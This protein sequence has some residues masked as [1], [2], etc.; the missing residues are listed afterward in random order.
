MKAFN[1]G[2]GKTIHIEDRKSP[3]TNLGDVDNMD[4]DED[5][6]DF[7]QNLTDKDLRSVFNGLVEGVRRRPRKI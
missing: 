1:A 6:N 5:A 4:I 7:L 3:L 2:K